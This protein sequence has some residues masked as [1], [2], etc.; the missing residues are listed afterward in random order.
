[1]HDLIQALVRWARLL[2]IP[3]G[4]GR[5]RPRPAHLRAAT[6]PPRPARLPVLRSPYGLDGPLNG[7]ETAMVRPYLLADEQRQRRLAL[8]LAAD[9]GL[10]LD[11]HLVGMQGAA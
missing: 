6:V 3:P 4:T 7:H 10:D 2:F 11:H 9:F 5:H 1:M 8:V